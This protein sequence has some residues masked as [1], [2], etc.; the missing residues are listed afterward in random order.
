[1]FPILRLRILI[2]LTAVLG[3]WAWASVEPSLRSI[4]GTSGLSLLDAR[5]GLIVAVALVLI[6]GLPALL[7]GLFTSALGHPLSGLFAIACALTAL[8]ISGGPMEGFLRSQPL[9][10]AYRILIMETLL[11]HVGMLAV[12]IVGIRSFG[13]MLRRGFARLA[14]DDHLGT[15]TRFTKPDVNAWMAGLLTTGI[16][17]FLGHLLLRSSDTGQVV[18][19][20]IAAF[21]LGSLAAQWIFPQH[22]PL[23]MLLSPLVISLIGYSYALLNFPTH[24]SLL[25]AWYAQRLS[26][27]ALALPIHYV[28]A[29]IVGVT[30]GIGWAQSL[31]YSSDA[32]DTDEQISASPSVR[33]S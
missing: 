17:G 15:H 31:I 25:E 22:N 10:N 5:T 7:L 20:L 2:L 14:T 1:M 21:A 19:G 12:V 3:G 26:G 29:G 11:W 28:S 16:A 18:G 23:P 33:N 30:L 24:E 9:P 4:E 27:L 6:S 32:D 13:P 8:A